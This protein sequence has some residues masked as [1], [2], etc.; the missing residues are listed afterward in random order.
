M[1]TAWTFNRGQLQA[2]LERFVAEGPAV[3]RAVRQSEADG[4]LMVLDSEA[5][6]KLRVPHDVG[7]R[8]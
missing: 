2:A 7:G 1:S 5:F 3:T 4:A 8:T 6:T